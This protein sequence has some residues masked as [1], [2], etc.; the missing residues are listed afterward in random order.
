MRYT[1][2]ELTQRILESMESDEVSTVGETPESTSVANIIKE[3][4]FD[5]VGQH[6]MA[7][8]EGLYKL[9]SAADSTKPTLMYVPENL[10][11]IKWIKYENFEGD[12]EEV[13]FVS[14]EEFLYYQE[15]IDLDL[16]NTG[17]MVVEVNGK[18][19]KFRFYKNQ[20]P[21]V[22]TVF[23]DYYVIFDGYDDRTG[24][25]LT[26]DRTTVFGMLVPGFQ[27][28]DTWI[29]DLDPRQFQLLLQEAKAQ[30]FIELKQTAN[31][32]AEAKAR[33]NHILTQKNKRDMDPEYANQ[34]H[35]GFGRKSRNGFPRNQLQ[36]DM[37]RG[38]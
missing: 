36:R 21:S 26:E 5:I 16:A 25:T 33:K 23:D 15:G 13:R 12:R 8:Q 31:P 4:Y 22:Y 28:V 24:T 34:A 38:S 9:D 37:R 30:A 27:L 29:P 20:T 35:A 19:F 17:E 10:S 11:R 14:N 18:P 2:L 7:E 32:K 3:C 6:S 1:L